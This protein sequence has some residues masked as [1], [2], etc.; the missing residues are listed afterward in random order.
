M[1]KTNTKAIGPKTHEGGTGEHQTAL[2][3]LR[4]TLSTCLLFEN[5]F[6]EGADSIAERLAKLAAQVQEDE[7]VAE[8]HRAKAVLKLRHAPLWLCVQLTKLHKGAQVGDTIAWCIQRADEL[9]EILSMYWRGGKRPI[10]KQLRRGLKIAFLKFDEY[11]LAR[12]IGADNT[13]KLRDVLFMV[14]PKPANDKVELFNKIANKQLQAPDTWQVSLSAGKNKKETW[15]RL[16]QENKLGNLDLLRN[17]RNMEAAGVDHGLVENALLEHDYNNVL[18]F[19]FVAAW[20]YAPVYRDTLDTVLRKAIAD[21][22]KLDGGTALV[23]DVS[24]SMEGKLSEKSDLTRLDAAGALAIQ[25]YAMCNTTYIWTFSS[26][27]QNVQVRTWGLGLVESIANSQHHGGTYLANSLRE[28]NLSTF[29]RVIVITD[30]QTADG[31]VDTGAEKQYLINVAPYQVGVDTQGKWIRIN[32]F[33]TAILQ[34]IAD[35][36]A[37]RLFG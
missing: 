7:L 22:P 11:H 10:S 20:R 37:A 33:S 28:V 9:A 31:I 25:L 26:H 24:G 16:L 8:I 4:R 13:V 3:E 36:E 15:E 2:Q 18:P 6:Y 12:N 5:T 17:L 29:H 19:Q 35:E 34:W 32:G 27:M 14:H 1:A 21:L 30:E 23:V